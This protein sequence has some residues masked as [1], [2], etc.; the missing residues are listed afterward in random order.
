MPRERPRGAPPT[1]LVTGGNGQIGFELTRSLAPLGRVIALDRGGCNLADIGQLRGVVRHF[2][3]DIIVNAAAY[4]A[5]DKAESDAAQAFAINGTA[6]GVLAE[7]AS[8]LGALLVH[9]STD[10]VFDGTKDDPYTEADTPHPV[11]AY[12]ES[13]LAGETAVL[14]SEASALVLRTSW[15]FGSH[16]IN[17]ART[18][19]KLGCDR[20]RLRVVADQSGAPTPA[21]LVADVTAQIVARHWIFGSPTAFPCGLYHLTASGATTWH[22][23]ALEVLRIAAAL[24]VALKVDPA[25]VEPIGTDDYPLPARRPAN[26]RLATARLCQVFGIHLPDWQDGLHAVM[27]EL[28]S[29]LP[30]S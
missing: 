10:Y 2:A 30:R 16:G 8:A 14:N 19:L 7:E 4:T 21:A 17:F 18:M 25:R 22:A 23:Y 27:P 28:V 1:L 11:S 29:Q 26:S 6:P 15:V 9:Y 24:G 3:P 5:V 13:K 12:G 20:D